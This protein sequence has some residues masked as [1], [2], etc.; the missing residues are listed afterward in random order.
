M[1]LRKDIR[2]ILSNKTI[3]RQNNH[4]NRQPDIQQDKTQQDMTHHHK[5]LQDG[6]ADGSLPT[7]EEELTEKINKVPEEE[8]PFQPHQLVLCR[9][10][11]FLQTVRQGYACVCWDYAM[12][13]P[14]IV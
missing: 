2:N 12:V 4:G 11:S 14:F 10:T 3:T 7:T 9:Q 13:H 6:E 8:Q 5:G 1:K